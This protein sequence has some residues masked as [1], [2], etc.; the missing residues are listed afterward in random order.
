MNGC[1][2]GCYYYTD[3][4]FRT[5]CFKGNNA[6]PAPK[7]ITEK[8]DEL[9][10]KRA[11]AVHSYIDA[12]LALRDK[13][14]D[15]RAIIHLAGVFVQRGQELDDQARA[16][17][18]WPQYAATRNFASDLT[19]LAEAL[20]GPR[21][22]HCTTLSAADAFDHLDEMFR[23]DDKPDEPWDEAQAILEGWNLFDVEG[24]WQL[25]RDDEAKKFESDAEA[26]IFV[27]GKANEGSDY[28]MR[29]IELIGT[30]FI[31]D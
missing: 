30:L 4:C 28:H 19:G 12:F 29:A 27:A 10:T 22:I 5:D 3:S 13:M 1:Y 26:I 18:G 9:S 31:K 17:I 2:P 25:Q 16:V 21:N 7:T 14:N 24:R 20:H 6:M 8:L 15:L 11:S 23:D